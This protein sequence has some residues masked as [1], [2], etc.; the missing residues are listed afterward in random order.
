MAFEL[1][2]AL[3]VGLID[4]LN[5]NSSYTVRIT[6]A[7]AQAYAAA[8]DATARAATTI[9][10]LIAAVDALT[11]CT[12]TTRGIVYVERDDAAVAP[13]AG[14]FRGNKFVTGFAGSGRNFVTSLAG[15]DDAAVNY[16]GLDVVIIGG[17]TATTNYVDAFNA[18][19]LDINGT[20]AT[21][22]YIR[23]ND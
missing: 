16:N 10:V 18:V 1:Q 13:A 14:V 7:A 4:N 23:A 2:P 3:T 8:A 17:T 21:L 19:A 5:R 22:Q 9:G 12:V 11:D 20:A 15:R 6:A